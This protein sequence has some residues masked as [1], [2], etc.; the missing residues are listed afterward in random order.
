MLLL[1]VHAEH[2]GCCVEATGMPEYAQQVKSCLQQP[3][4]TSNLCRRH[5]PCGWR[6]LNGMQ[7]SR[8]VSSIAITSLLRYLESYLEM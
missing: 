7:Q 4:D 8:H 2:M 6:L 1:L 5:T 3:L